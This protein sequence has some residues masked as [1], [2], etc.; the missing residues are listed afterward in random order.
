MG[1]RAGAGAGAARWRGDTLARV[2]YVVGLVSV[3]SPRLW[4]ALRACGVWRVGGH[5]RVAFWST[6]SCRHDVFRGHASVC[7]SALVVGV[8][9]TRAHLRGVSCAV[10]G[11]WSRAF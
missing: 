6:Q 5:L 1:G 2:R 4:C 10:A 7:V 3:A 8:A 11:A 9:R